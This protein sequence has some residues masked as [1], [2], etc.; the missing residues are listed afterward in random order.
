[1]KPVT[2][3]LIEAI[4]L[5]MM[6]R[7]AAMWDFGITSQGHYA[8]LHFVV[9][10]GHVTPEALDVALGNGKELTSIRRTQATEP[11]PKLR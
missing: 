9:R 1:M 3:N 7:Q 2:A 5:D 8:A 11:K 4:M 10:Q 6:P